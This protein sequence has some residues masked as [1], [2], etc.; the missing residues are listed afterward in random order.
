VVHFRKKYELK[1][2]QIK[3]MY[4]QGTALL[5]SV[6][7]FAT[8]SEHL[9]KLQNCLSKKNKKNQVSHHIMSVKCLQKKGI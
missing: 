2:T 7:G 6:D 5:T 3:K 8:V 9:T 4:S 1:I